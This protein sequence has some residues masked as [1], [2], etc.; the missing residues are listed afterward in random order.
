MN[1]N[2]KLSEQIISILAELQDIC[3][4]SIVKD[5]ISKNKNDLETMHKLL[6]KYLRD[7][8]IDLDSELIN[9][10]EDNGEN[11]KKKYFSF[12]QLNEVII[13]KYIKRIEKIQKYNYK[14]KEIC[15]YIEIYQQDPTSEETS[16]LIS[17]ETKE[18]RDIGLEILKGK[19]KQMGLN[20]L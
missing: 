3:G 15:Y 19:L 11:K 5:I 16:F 20:I 8:Y 18:K 1:Q 14:K 9:N 12:I 17:F 2:E 4:S 7:I 10:D 13:D 6:Y